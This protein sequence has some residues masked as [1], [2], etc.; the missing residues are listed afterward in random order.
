[1]GLQAHN[2]FNLIVGDLATKEVAYMTNRG[3]GP[4][5][6][7]VLLPG[8]HAVSNNTLHDGSWPK[9]ERSVQLLKVL[10]SLSRCC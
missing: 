2:G 9:A 8:I 5:E 6:P 10:C 1:M 3:N 7:V 4:R